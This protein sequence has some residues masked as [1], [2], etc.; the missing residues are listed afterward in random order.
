MNL[1]FVTKSFSQK[2]STSLAHLL[3]HPEVFEK[4]TI[5]WK[6]HTFLLFLTQ[7]SKMWEIQAKISDER[8]GWIIGGNIL[9]TLKLLSAFLS[10]CL[11]VYSRKYDFQKISSYLYLSDSSVIQPRRS[12]L[13]L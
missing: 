2:N 9:G 3:K 5:F 13:T 10:G 4:T 12:V 1:F 7:K 8:Q 11:L 6:I